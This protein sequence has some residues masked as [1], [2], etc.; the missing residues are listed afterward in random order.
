[1]FKT[2]VTSF[3]VGLLLVCC[4]ETPVPIDDPP[5]EDSCEEG[6]CPTVPTIHVSIVSHNEEPS[7]PH[8]PDFVA[9]VDV[10]WEQREAIVS[11]ANMLHAEDVKYNYQSDWNFLLAA[12]QYDHGT[13]ETNGKNFLRYLREDLGFEIDPHAHEIRYDDTQDWESHNYA[14]VAYLIEV[15]GVSPS[16]AVGGFIAYPPQNSKLE[17]FREPLT[18]WKYPNH[19]WQ[20]ELLWGGNTNQHVDDHLVWA[21]GIWC[22]TNNE[23]FLAH[24]DDAPLP[25]IGYV[26]SSWPGLYALLDKLENGE[27]E[28]DKIYTHTISVGQNDMAGAHFV[29]NFQQEIQALSDHV[30]AG[31]INW[32]GLTD[33]INIWRDKY[34]SRPNVYRPESN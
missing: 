24:D 4:G 12:T 1:M 3:F 15:L 8:Y 28:P 17:Y 23:E 2:T 10:F 21:S 33:L 34:D 29:S 27:L 6:Q 25:H 11:F 7:A 9:D 22:P 14:D 31:A 20:A 26:K 32:V 5:N 30:T 19:T 13:S 16:G 18:G